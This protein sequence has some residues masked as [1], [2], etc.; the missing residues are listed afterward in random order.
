M[1][2]NPVPRGVPSPLAAAILAI[3]LLALPSVAAAQTFPGFW[4][5]GNQVYAPCEYTPYT[6]YIDP[7]TGYERYM[8]YDFSTMR[9]DMYRAGQ[10]AGYGGANHTLQFYGADGKIYPLLPQGVAH[11]IGFYPGPPAVADL[12]TVYVAKNPGRACPTALATYKSLLSQN[13]VWNSGVNAFIDRIE[14]ECETSPPPPPTPTPA[15]PGCRGRTNGCGV[16]GPGRF[17]NTNGSR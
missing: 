1:D 14:D 10:P 12:C 3:A 5:V 8:R 6:S 4:R 7:S 2:K 17:N 13:V 16:P 9:P 11:P 15:P